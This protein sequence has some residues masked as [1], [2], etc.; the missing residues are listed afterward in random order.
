MP[1]RDRFDDDDLDDRPRRSRHHDDPPRR[2]RD[3]S[4]GS[5]KKPGLAI[6]AAILWLIWAGILLLSVLFR[7]FQL[8]RGDGDVDPVCGAIDLLL[9]LGMALLSG[10]AGMMTLF[11]KTRSLTSFGVVSLVMPPAI[12]L[13]ETALA[14]L[15]GLAATRHGPRGSDLPLIMAFRSFLFTTLLVSGVILAGIFALCVNKKY[16]AWCSRQG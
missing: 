8:F 15:I 9:I 6:A 1:R 3:I 10:G 16:R 4:Y 7:A 5:A 11:G 14:F 12:V 2:S 13:M